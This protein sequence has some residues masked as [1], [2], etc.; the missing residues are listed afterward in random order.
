MIR[1]RAYLDWNAS[2]P[3]R[4]EARA[5]MLG[6]LDQIG[7]PSSVHREGRAA[8]AI[9]ET[10]RA[11]IAAL[12]G[13]DPAAIVFT[14]GAT[15]AA[16]MALSNRKAIAWPSDHDSVT[17]HARVD[18]TRLG[19]DGRAIMPDLSSAGEQ[20]VFDDVDIA[21][22]SH[23]S[24]ETGIIQPVEDL[25][26]LATSRQP[27]LPTLCD[28][29]QTLGRMP[30][31]FGSKPLAGSGLDLAICSAHKLG[32]PKGVGALVILGDHRPPA[33]LRGGGQESGHRSGTENV[34]GIAGFGAAAEA[35]RREVENGA[36]ERVAHL[37]DLLEE[38]LESAAPDLIFM[39]KEAPRLPNTSCFALPGW[40]GETQV[41]QMDLG[42]F[43]VSAGSACSSGKVR[44][45]SPVLLAM[46]FDETTASSAIRVS[47]GPTTTED[48]VMAF[49]DT[50]I[51][52][53]HRRG[54]RAA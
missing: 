16:S 36:W 6:V 30:L 2:T 14:S 41:M 43:A 28:I 18:G 3:L 39:G 45:A 8:R 42:G 9:T 32:G 27:R 52:R 15:E 40:T 48:Q 4:P 29:S 44:R 26:A 12:L 53:Y 21:A 49:A 7:N 34:A 31:E 10:A 47:I 13:C 19:R 54:E 38:R 23:A 11:Q 50:W 24:G 35:A 46:G 20:S 1:E 33:L 37:R 51:S 5:A 25:L 17:A 22:L